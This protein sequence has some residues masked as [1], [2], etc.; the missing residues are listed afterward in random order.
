MR[1]FEDTT[2]RFSPKFNT[3]LYINIEAAILVEIIITSFALCMRKDDIITISIASTDG[4]IK[5]IIFT[6]LT[7][8]I[9]YIYNSSGIIDWKSNHDSNYLIYVIIVTSTENEV[10]IGKI[11]IY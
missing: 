7:T 3:L 9:T 4:Y 1:N 2:S 11:M 5:L 6:K 10:V 8:I